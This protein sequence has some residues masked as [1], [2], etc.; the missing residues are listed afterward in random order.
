MSP[1]INR[2][3]RTPGRRRG[4][5]PLVISALV[6][7]ATVFVTFYAFNEGLPFVHHFSLNAVV[8]NSVAV[9]SGS[10]VR[11][12]GVDVG[13]VTGVSPDGEATR[14]NFTLS[15][16]GQPVHADATLRIRPR[17][18]LEGGY[19]LELDP[20][21][22]GARILKD[23]GTI[24]LAQ[25]QTPVQFYNVLST[26]DSATRG[27]LQGL[28]FTLDRGL[29]GYDITTGRPLPD[30]GAAGLRSVL[31]H[32]APALKDV[33]RVTRALRG[34]AP[35]DVQRLLSSA[36]EV[37]GTLAGSSSQLADLVTSL[38][39][40][41]SALAATDGSLAQS[42]AG[43]DQTLQSAPSALARIDKALPPVVKLAQTIDPSLKVAPPLVDGVTQAVGDLAAIVAPAERAR[44]LTALRSTF[45]QFPGLLTKLG[46][47][48]PVAKSVTDCLRT[49]VT[50]ILKTIVPDGA[51]SSSRPVWQDFVHFLGG[52][53]GA[54]QNFDANGHWIRLLAGAGT[55]SISLGT[56]PLLGQIG[57]TGPPGGSTIQGA[58]P[59]WAGD[60]TSA[61]FQPGVPCAT[62][63]VPSLAAPT[64][65]AD[66]KAFRSAKP[67]AL[68]AARV[69][70]AF[71]R[72]AKG[73]K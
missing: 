39:A 73:G 11:I 40:T 53:A 6:I 49:H 72:A 48:F 41:S 67:T 3:R 61:D 37:T 54:S 34:T 29:G 12:A 50:P 22:P 31:P 13:A 20:G 21:S 46:S 57:G 5:H 55:N 8:N 24:P 64:G 26:F 25:T 63:S 42:V 60:L 62:Q 58:R 44:L 2:R 51:L 14:I 23:R 17:V 69:L 7:L 38:N 70:A 9:R 1:A 33:A 35:G 27:T 59:V 43:L 15:D 32:F 56:L 36:S 66:T 16:N 65:A 4:M 10:P 19:Y 30:S 68:D 28:L 45:E 52:L 71:A 18:F 47:A